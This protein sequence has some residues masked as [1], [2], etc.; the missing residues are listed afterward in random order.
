MIPQLIT[1]DDDPDRPLV[2]QAAAGD[3]LAFEQLVRKYEHW[4]YHTILKITQVHEDAEDQTQETFIRVHR[5]LANFRGNSRFK[6][7]LT[8][9]AMNQAL[10]CRR[11]RK[12]NVV[13]MYRQFSDDQEGVYILDIVDPGTNPEELWARTR[14]QDCLK[15]EISRLPKKL[16]SAFVM[17]FIQESNGAETAMSLNISLAAVKSRVL[18]ARKILQ[19]RVDNTIW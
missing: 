14:L 15:L 17:R 13:S 8:R 19:K 4:V 10:Q 3:A 18:R 1:F 11:K 9:I 2:E 7:W 16:R 12:P 5:S 6:T